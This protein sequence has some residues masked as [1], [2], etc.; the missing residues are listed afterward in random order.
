MKNNF[1]FHFLIIFFH[2]FEVVEVVEMV[3]VVD[4]SEEDENTNQGIGE[5]TN[6]YFE[7]IF[8]SFFFPMF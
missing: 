6:F 8:V 1:E 7:A 4:R 2:A 5:D 3:E